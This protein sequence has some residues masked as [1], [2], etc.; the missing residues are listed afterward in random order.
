ML[1]VPPDDSSCATAAAAA[2]ADG[3]APEAMPGSYSDGGTTGEPPRPS[4][5]VNRLAETERREMLRP[6][7]EDML[8]AGRCC[9]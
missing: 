5:E 8:S 4:V 2:A 3:S 1:S 7:G 6:E 9:G